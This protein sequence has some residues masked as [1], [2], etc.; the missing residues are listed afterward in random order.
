MW[1]FQSIHQPEKKILLLPG[2]EYVLGRR[3]CDIIIENDPSVSRK[4]AILKVAHPEANVQHPDKLP[5]L[6]FKDISKFGTLVNGVKISGELELKDGDEVKFGAPKSMHRAVFEPFVVTASCL[7]SQA[8][9]E[10]RHL[11]A[12]MGGHVSSDWQ[13]DC[14]FLLMK[15]ITVTVKVVCALVSQKDIVTSSFLRAYFKHLTEGAEKP[16]PTTFLPPVTERLVNPDVSFSRDIRRSS[17]FL[18]MTFYFLCK[19]QFEKMSLVVELGGGV[20]ILCDHTDNTDLDLLVEHK[21][22]VMS[23]Q[24]DTQNIKQLEFI[25]KVTAY[26]QKNKKYP[27]HDAEI[28]YAVIYCS[29]EDY[30]NPDKDVSHLLAMPLASQSLSHSQAGS[31]TSQAVTGGSQRPAAQPFKKPAGMV[32]VT[33]G[34][35][36]TNEDG[37][38]EKRNSTRTADRV[39]AQE[40]EHSLG[41]G[42]GSASDKSASQATTHS[43]KDTVK[44][45]PFA[46]EEMYSVAAAS[47]VDSNLNVGPGS[48]G[49]RSRSSHTADSEVAGRQTCSRQSPFSQPAD[50]TDAHQARSE[51][52][53]PQ[54]AVTIARQTRSR[55][56]VPQRAEV[57]SAHQTRSRSRS[58]APKD[59]PVDTKQP[60]SSEP[61]S[62]TNRLSRSRSPEKHQM[63][64]PDTEMSPGAAVTMGGDGETQVKTEKEINRVGIEKENRWLT[65]HDTH[66]VPQSIS[67][68]AVSEAL[69][70][71]EDTARKPVIKTEPGEC[72]SLLSDSDE[73]EVVSRKPAPSKHRRCIDV[74]GSNDDADDPFDFGKKRA[75][76]PKR[77]FEKTERESRPHAAQKRERGKSQERDSETGMSEN[78]RSVEEPVN[79]TRPARAQNGESRSHPDMPI[80]QGFLTTRA[81]IKSQMEPNPGFARENI[82][83]SN[84]VVKFNELLRPMS[85]R[86]V[87]QRQNESIV[88]AGMMMWKGKLVPNFK[89]FCKVPHAGAGQLPRIIGGRDLEEHCRS[90]RK[91]MDNWLQDMQRVETQQT[92][93]DREAQELFNYQPNTSRGRS[94]RR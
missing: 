1:Y 65:S 42:T 54:H 89:K 90:S 43:L 6:T 27:I 93:R 4:H 88:P 68:V 47:F 18:G 41:R 9:K 71:T 72:V 36:N 85:R 70:D 40:K 19:K 66:S 11:M 26:L 60:K 74:S 23:P 77:A 5:V 44:T 39:S 28:G 17:V 53:A 58:P 94:N 34:A 38:D 78:S 32:H 91:E 87:E 49:G 8:K 35:R 29:T 22:V 30:C 76:K 57:I 55:S 62:A 84:V 61:P 2:R 63:V 45:E 3:E 21:A 79:T 31:L 64:I 80:P 46:T 92:Q 25:E 81:P 12:K 75:K 7:D 67:S 50:I 14:S 83:S 20:P 13:K 82:A 48:C 59:I 52:P 86:N 69:F 33:T 24:S 51:S 73:E 16:D 56:P 37:I 10:V 15:N